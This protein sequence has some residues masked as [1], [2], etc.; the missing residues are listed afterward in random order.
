MPTLNDALDRLNTGRTKEGQQI[1]ERLLQEDPDNPTILYNLGMAYSEQGILEQ[2]IQVLTRCVE[3]DPQYVNAYAALGFSYAR[4][5]M[6][7]QAA[8]VLETALALDP[9]NFYALR[10]LGSVYGRQDRLEDAQRCFE[11]ANELNPN[12]PEILYG[13]ALIYERQGMIDIADL[14][15]KKLIEESPDERFVELAKKARTRIGMDILKA[16]GV[17]ID[18]LMYCLSALQKFSRMDQSRVQEI[19]FEI[20]IIGM[21]GLKIN[22]PNKKYALKTLPGEFTG[23]QLLCYMYVGFQILDPTVDVGADLSKEYH[24]AL[25]MLEEGHLGVAD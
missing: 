9:H 1:L 13:L 12:Q 10:N 3:L 5:E 17:R 23:L 4:S 8:E 19:S 25:Q 22:N 2:S 24:A 21:G 16:Q 7:D 14:I 6:F 11:E 18:A 15:H 20:A